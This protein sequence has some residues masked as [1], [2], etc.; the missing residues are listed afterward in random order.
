VTAQPAADAA[1]VVP[2][3]PADLAGQ[4]RSASQQLSRSLSTRR[5]GDVWMEYLAPD[6]ISQWMASG[7]SAELHELLTHYDGVVG[8]PQLSSIAAAR[9]FATTR[10]LLRQYVSQHAESAE[11]LVD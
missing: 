9:G 10:S 6:R 1:K 3:N 8:N 4:L 7:N 11:P 2:V 5:D